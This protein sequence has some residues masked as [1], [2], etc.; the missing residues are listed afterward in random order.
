M[1]ALEKY[2]SYPVDKCLN[3]LQTS[4]NGL[5]ESEALQRINEFGYNEIPEKKEESLFMKILETFKEPMILILLAASVFSVIIKDYLEAIVILGV[6]IINNAV[7]IIQDIKAGKAVDALKKMLTPEAKVWRGGKLEIAASRYIVPGDILVFE[8]GDIIAADARVIE[9]SNVLADEA[10][11]T[12][13]SV[14]VEKNLKAIN[15]E[16]IR[17]HEMK[18]IV[19]AGSKIQSG[20]G[21]AVAVATGE[22]TQMGAIASDI[23][24]TEEEKTPLQKKLSSEMNFLVIL[25]FIAAAFV[26]MVLFI[27]DP[28]MFRN[29]AKINEAILVAISIMIAMFPEGMPAAITITLSIVI[30]RLAKNSVIVKKLSSVETLG[31]VDYIC[32]DKTGTITQHN[33]TVKELYS[34]NQ[35]YS[36]AEVFS[37]TAA[38]ENLVLYDIFLTSVKCSTA[39]V[40]EKNG[41]IVQEIG[42][43]TETALIKFAILNG[44]KPSQFNTAKINDNLPFSSDIMY[45]AI[46]VDELESKKSAYIKGATEKVLSFCSHY[47]DHGALKELDS[48]VSLKIL[49]ELNNRA[50]KGFRLISFAKKSCPDNVSKLNNVDNSGYV[51]LGTAVIYDPP[52]DEVKHVIAEAKQ[53]LI[54]V[55]MITGDSRKTGFSIAE[56]VGIAEDISQTIEGKEIAKMNEVEFARNVEKFRVY[57]RVSPSDKYRIVETLKEKDHV[58]AM[59]GDGVNDAPALKKADVGI[60]MGK[61]GTQVAREAADIIL[62]EDDFS[63]IVRA[64]KEG[65]TVYQNL[66]KLVRYL[67]TNN[68]GKVIAIVITPLISKITGVAYEVPLLAVQLLW[69]NVIMEGVPGVGISMDK[70]EDSI[71]KKKPDSLKEPIISRKDKMQMILDGIV[72]GICIIAGYVGVFHLT[73]NQN[74]ARTTA[75]MICLLSPQIFVFIIREGSLKHRFFAPNKTLKIFLLFT[76]AMMAIL[77]YVP[78]FQSIFKTAPIYDIRL[79]GIILILSLVTS[80]FRFLT[81]KMVKKKPE[82]T[83]S[84]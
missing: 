48:N 9:A 68:M 3:E 11:L 55:V 45:S 70:P 74:A 84:L 36:S 78:A 82:T 50:E 26:V 71:M 53:A 10:H 58:I 69:T 19:F 77:V 15:S 66:K 35:F 72:F 56:N 61:A 25:S 73:G 57:S 6:V 60:A 14:T 49:K 5:T 16:E 40:E 54:N 4:E 17:L 64:V 20:F 23:Q 13:E 52:K 29:I 33:M 28:Q 43:P 42:D 34:G 2:C 37:I 1:N 51:Y 38:G 46:L 79:W 59:T 30:E 44:Y 8:S 18:N 75:F 63:T 62:A 80:T 31:N 65:R 41:N 27:K 22:N 32:T 12:G 81:E 67:L 24:D 76:L 83:V 39:S 21:K 7:S 47:Y